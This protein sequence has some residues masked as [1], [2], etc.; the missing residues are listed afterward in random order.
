M[1][2]GDVVLIA[3]TLGILATAVYAR[4][5]VRIP[6]VNELLRNLP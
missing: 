3:I 4:L 6:S 2:R 1:H 5:F